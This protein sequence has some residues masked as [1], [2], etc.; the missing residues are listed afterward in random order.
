MKE[1]LKKL[2]K[3]HKALSSLGLIMLG[4][5]LLWVIPLALWGGPENVIWKG[6]VLYLLLSLPVFTIVLV[7]IKLVFSGILEKMEELESEE[8]FEW[9]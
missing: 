3:I 9:L 6:M 1:E 2:R 7:V 8:E 5:S 4:I